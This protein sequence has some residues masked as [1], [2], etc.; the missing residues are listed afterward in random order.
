MLLG[1][2]REGSAPVVLL[3]KDEILKG[4]TMTGPWYQVKTTGGQEG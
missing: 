1:Q 3:E 4:Q 2:P